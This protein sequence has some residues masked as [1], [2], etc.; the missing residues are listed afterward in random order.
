M[1]KSAVL[2][3]GGQDSTT[4]FIKAWCTS[5]VK[6]E[7]AFYMDYGSKHRDAEFVCAERTAGY[8]GDVPLDCI[9]IRDLMSNSVSGLINPSIGVGEAHPLNPNLPA[10]FV[11]G[12]NLL[13]IVLAAQRC[14]SLGI[15]HLWTGV[16]ETD[17]SGYPDCRESTIT[18]LES[19]IRLGMDFPEF[20]IVTPLMHLTKAETFKM[21]QDE[22]VLEYIIE[23]THTGYTGERAVLYSWGWG[24]ENEEDLDPAS[25][26]RKK[27]YEEFL[28]MS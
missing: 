28:K 6:V 22:G 19:A 12:R 26:I 1:K 9:D 15:T 14:Y 21:A 23:N 10:S 27:G 11:P 7:R 4:C 24:P 2:L 20:T 18:A 13:F 3:S 17:Y 16:C 5:D 8:F 25:A